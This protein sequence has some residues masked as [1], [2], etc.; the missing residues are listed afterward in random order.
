MGRVSS[1]VLIRAQD[2]RDA[3]V[4][5]GYHPQAVWVVPGAV[6][7]EDAQPM[8]DRIVVLL[9]VFLAQ[10]SPVAGKMAVNEAGRVNSLA[11]HGFQRSRRGHDLAKREQWAD[12]C[13]HRVVSSLSVQASFQLWPE[14][15]QAWVRLQ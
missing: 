15:T 5:L 10:V 1:L 9:G 8:L 12:W 6:G 14:D 2:R 4:S 7:R 3:A 11:C 13:C